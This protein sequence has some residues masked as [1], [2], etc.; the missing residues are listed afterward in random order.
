M[1]RLL[2][3]TCALLLSGMLAHAQA[4]L[5]NPNY[6]QSLE[7]YTALGADLTQT[8]NTTVQNTYKAYDWQEAKAERKRL[9][10]EE[11]MY[12][13]N[14]PWYGGYYGR[15]R[16]NNFGYNSCYNN[17]NYGYNNFCCCHP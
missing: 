12:Y 3:S 2:L 16:Y 10:R 4:D 8:M 17:N 9:R 7:R 13:Y 6:R 1:K 14:R 11:R 15:Y 5:Q